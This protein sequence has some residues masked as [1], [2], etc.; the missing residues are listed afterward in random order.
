[1]TNM[2]LI[3][4]NEVKAFID[5]KEDINRKCGYEMFKVIDIDRDPVDTPDGE[6][7]SDNWAVTMYNTISCMVFCKTWCITFECGERKVIE[8]FSE[9]PLGAVKKIAQKIVEVA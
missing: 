2:E 7:Y 5:D 6:M 9:L 4:P 8:N 3:M 1:M